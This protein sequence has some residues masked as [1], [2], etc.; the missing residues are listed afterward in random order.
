VILFG[1]SVDRKFALDT[2]FVVCDDYVDYGPQ[3]YDTLIQQVDQTYRIVTISPI[4][5]QKGKAC[6]QTCAAK[7]IQEILRSYKGATFDNQVNA[8][9]SFFPCQ[10]YTKNSLGFARPTIQMPTIS[11]TQTQGI[12]ITRCSVDNISNYWREVVKQ[13]TETCSLGIFAEIPIE[14][15]E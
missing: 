6:N 9:F 10:A 12:K 14:R 1:S 4:V 8:T 13:V 7:I 15:P 11:D 2:V 5:K 3:N